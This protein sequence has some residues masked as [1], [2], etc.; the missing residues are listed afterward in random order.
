[1]QEAVVAY[2]QTAKITQ[3]PR[4]LEGS[5]LL[6]SAVQLQSIKDDFENKTN[7]LTEAL[8]Y[9]RKLWTLFMTSA[10]DD[11]HPL[12]TEVKNNIASLGVFIANHTLEVLKD[13]TPA[14]LTTLININREIAAGLHSGDA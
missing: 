10:T 1:M 5:L 3:T 14:K 6:K 9:N 8:Y 4:D 11:S 2:S 7:E 12:P 13:P